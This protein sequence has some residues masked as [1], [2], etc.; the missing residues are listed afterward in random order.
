MTSLNWAFPLVSG[1]I[2]AVILA[3]ICI[4]LLT[5]LKAGQPIRA[6]GPKSHQA[7]KG[8]P[9]IGGIIFIFGAAFAYFLSLALTHASFSRE[10]LLVLF[11]TLSYGITGF[12]DDYRKVKFG[13]SLGLRAREKMALEVLFA[14]AFM[15]FFVSKGNYVILPFTGARID[16]GILYPIFGILVIV[17]TG[18]AVNLTDGLDGLA[19]GV[20][21]I[22]LLGYYAVATAYAKTLF[23]SPAT[24][25]LPYMILAFI[26]ALFG[27]LVFNYHPAKVIMGDTGALALGGL[28]AGIAIATK[29][30]LLLLFFAGVPFIEAVSVILQVASFQL[31]GKR[32]FKM[33][34]LHHHF[35]LSGWKE[36]SVVHLFWAFQ[37]ILGIL[38]LVAMAYV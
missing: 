4:P 31:F 35:E 28:L 22:G 23:V 26:G 30:E 17:G 25:G 7:K 19:T 29:S 32:I 38:G 21:I 14:A 2:F 18:N 12:I 3:R 9:T 20:T 16:L 34:P 11:L 5:R 33:S 24:F 1:F 13:R 36:T 8:T 27:F 37:L 15:W 10:D 6:E